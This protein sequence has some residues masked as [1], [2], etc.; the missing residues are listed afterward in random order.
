MGNLSEVLV[1]MCKERWIALGSGGLHLQSYLLKRSGRITVWSQ[2]RQIVHE[3]LSHK[4]KNHTRKYGWKNGSR[5]R[6]AHLTSMSPWD[7]TRLPP[8]KKDESDLWLFIGPGFLMKPILI[9]PQTRHPWPFPYLVIYWFVVVFLLS[10]FHKCL[11]S[12]KTMPIL[13]SVSKVSK[14]MNEWIKKW[15]NSN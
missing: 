1:E 13:F 7:Q 8:K 3:A 12:L 2:P 5:S 4:K 10:V 6:A 15:T 9:T 11:H 14:R